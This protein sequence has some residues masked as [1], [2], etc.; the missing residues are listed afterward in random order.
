MRVAGSEPLKIN[1]PMNP[2]SQP[3][4]VLSIRKVRAQ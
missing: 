3:F 1:T 2:L 4:V